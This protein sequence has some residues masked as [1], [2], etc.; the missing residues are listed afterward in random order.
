MSKVI[1][2]IISVDFLRYIKCSMLHEYIL[3]LYAK[4]S[5]GTNEKG[6]IYCMDVKKLITVFFKH[7][8]YIF[9]FNICFRPFNPDMFSLNVCVVCT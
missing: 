1:K 8:Y 6:V 9:L 4:L 2:V 5:L 7:R 3:T